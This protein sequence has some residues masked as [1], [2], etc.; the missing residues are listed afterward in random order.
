[1]LSQNYNKHIP[2]LVIS[3]YEHSDLNLL[4][5]LMV[6]EFPNWNFDK[7][8]RYISLVLKKNLTEY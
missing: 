7:L 5:P 3:K 1:M 2:G 8:K 6:E 4:L